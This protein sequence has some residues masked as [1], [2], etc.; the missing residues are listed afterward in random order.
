MA[1]MNIISFYL[2]MSV[3]KV[4]DTIVMLAGDQ[5]TGRMGAVVLIWLQAGC[6]IVM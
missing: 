6:V 2:S 5:S 1:S 4:L 3:L